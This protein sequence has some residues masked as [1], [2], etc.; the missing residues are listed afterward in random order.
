MQIF[1]DNIINV[2][3]VPSDD[4]TI[5]PAVVPFSLGALP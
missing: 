1:F 2:V 4:W 3:I 5:Q